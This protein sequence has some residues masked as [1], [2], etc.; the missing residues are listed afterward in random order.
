VSGRVDFGELDYPMFI[1]TVAARGERDGCLV[2]FTTQ[3]SIH[4]ERFMVCLSDKNRTFRIARYASVLGVHLVPQGA[5]ALAELFGSTTGDDI[6]KF[7]HCS[8][9]P[10]PGGAPILDDCDTWFAGRILDRLDV[11]DHSAFVL[12]PLQGDAQP[13]EEALSSQEAMAI[14]PGHEP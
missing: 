2:G 13:G 5:E 8:W 7:E 1:V 4:P 12:E 6:D 9:K 3:C 10:G 11:G 14:P